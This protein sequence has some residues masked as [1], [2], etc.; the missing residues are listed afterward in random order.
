MSDLDPISESPT[1]GQSPAPSGLLYAEDIE[2]GIPIELGTHYVSRDE[3][4]SFATQWDPQSF[5][6]DDAAGERSPFGGLI[7]S[8]LHS[9][10]IFQRLAVLRLYRHW[11]V[12]AGRA[13]R[14]VQLTS[15]LRPGA[16]VHAVVEALK[17]DLSRPDRALC[18][19]LGTLHDGERQ[20]L[21][22]ELDAYVLRRPA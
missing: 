14:D 13:M 4:V 12:I 16:T 7:G 15:P 10:C 9:M 11:A 2:I 18:T 3:I 1:P 17:V 22:F 20:L 21:S 5:H 8:G 6:I 19:S